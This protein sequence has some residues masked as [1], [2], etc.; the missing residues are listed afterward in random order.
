MLKKNIAIITFKLVNFQTHKK[1]SSAQS[2]N[3]FGINVAEKNPS[4]PLDFG[5]L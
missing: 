2:F 4:I 1:S 5:K 3:H